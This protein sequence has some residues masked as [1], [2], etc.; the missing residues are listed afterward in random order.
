[1]QEH[2]LGRQEAQQG[3]E[4]SEYHEPGLGPLGVRRENDQQD[5]LDGE[6][7]E[8]GRPERLNDSPGE[9]VEEG[10]ACGS[11]A[12]GVDPAQ[13]EQGEESEDDVGAGIGSPEEVTARCQ[14]WL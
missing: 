1:M 5:G 6:R 9:R 10:E 3:D 4:E 11:R 14:M 7:D 13:H 8:R 12:D 2:G